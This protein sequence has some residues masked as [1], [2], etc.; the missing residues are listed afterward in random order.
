MEVILNCDD[1]QEYIDVMRRDDGIDVTIDPHWDYSGRGM[2]G[3]ECFGIVGDAR[4]LVAF[5]LYV[6]PKLVEDGVT[7]L[8][9]W[10]HVRH[11]NMARETIF[12]W[13]DIEIES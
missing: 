3:A 2:F 10:L 6:V 12:Y 4:T 7:T 1:V 13:P 11:D 9:A 8:N 5:M